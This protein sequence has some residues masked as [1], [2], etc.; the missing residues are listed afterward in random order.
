MST[1]SIRRIA[2]TL[3]LPAN[4]VSNT[5]RLLEEGASIPFIARY[6]KELTGSLDE[7]QV[8]DIQREHKRLEDL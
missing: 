1:D 2:Q 6:R 4:K 5:L 7:V 3:Q 8:A